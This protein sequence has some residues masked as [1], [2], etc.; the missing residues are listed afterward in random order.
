MHWV[1][2]LQPLLEDKFN[3]QQQTRTRWNM[4]KIWWNQI[5][6]SSL[7]IPPASHSSLNFLSFWRLLPINLLLCLSSPSLST[8]TPT[9]YDMEKNL[10]V[11]RSYARKKRKKKKITLSWLP[12]FLPS[13]NQP[14]SWDP[15]KLGCLSHLYFQF[16]FYVFHLGCL[17]I[18]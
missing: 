3:L 15:W 11:M 13:A 12:G 7:Q 10:A 16:C 1:L 4:K 17:E 9:S 5:S 8:E 6:R 2:R 18:Q 14:N